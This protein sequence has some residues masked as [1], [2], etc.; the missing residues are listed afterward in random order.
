MSKIELHTAISFLDGILSVNSIPDAPRALN[1]LQLENGGTV[2][3]VAAAVDGSERP[4]MRPWKQVRTCSF[5]TTAFSGSPCSPLPAS[6][7]GS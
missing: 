4:F 5:F 1:G 3:K 2:S 7:T 6:P